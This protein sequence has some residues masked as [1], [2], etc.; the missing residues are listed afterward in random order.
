MQKRYNGVFF[1]IEA[2][3]KKLICIV[4]NVWKSITSESKLLI[5]LQEFIHRVLNMNDVQI[6]LRYSKTNPQ[7]DII[8]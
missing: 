7:S 4:F 2:T 1:T 5:F 6:H 3:E 8:C